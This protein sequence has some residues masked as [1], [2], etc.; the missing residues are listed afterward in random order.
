MHSAALRAL[1]L[2]MLVAALAIGATEP[3]LA[4]GSVRETEYSTSLT[5]ATGIV[6][7]IVAVFGGLIGLLGIVVAIK[8]VGGAADVSASVGKH[9]SLSMKRVSQGVV[10]TLI[11][12][13]VLVGALY[14]LPDKRTERELTGKEISIER[15]PGKTREIMKK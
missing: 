11:G 13:A 5:E 8:G 15:E 6:R 14:F 7:I 9:A 2:L 12:A 10:L 1:A 4:N 3:V